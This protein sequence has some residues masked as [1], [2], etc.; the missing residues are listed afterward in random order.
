MA[1]LELERATVTALENFGLAQ[2][3]SLETC[4]TV[5]D[6]DT[7]DLLDTTELP[8]A[9]VSVRIFICPLM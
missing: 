8:H 1:D 5:I 2:L 9:R 7:L 3:D 4:N 6:G